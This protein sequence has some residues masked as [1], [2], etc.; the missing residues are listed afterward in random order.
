MEQLLELARER[1]LDRVGATY[2]VAAWILVQAASIALPAFAAPAWVLR[3]LIVAAMAGFPLVLAGA[4]VKS[5]RAPMAAAP[6]PFDRKDWLLTGLIGLVAVLLLVQLALGFSWRSTRSASQPMP[7][8][9]VSS[10]AVLPFANLS[11]DPSKAYFSDG[12]ADQLISELARTPS[13]RVAART[14]SF[15]FRGKDVDIKAIAKALNVRSVL[16]GSVREDGNRVRIAAELVDASNGFQIWSQ[17][18][19]RDL[20]SILALQDEI[21][22]SISRAL[23]QRFWGKPGTPARPVQRQR[24][25]PEV[26]KLYLQGQY[27]L[28]QRTRDGVTRAIDLFKRVTENAP[29]YADGI[30][31]LAD[32]KSVDALNFEKLDQVNAAATAADKALTLDPRNATALL[33]RARI[34]LLKWKWRAVA[35]DLRQLDRLHVNTAIVWR[36]KAVFF[37]YMGLSQFSGAAEQKA[38]Q[39]DPLSFLDHYNI[40]LYAM[41]SKHYD[42]AMKAAGDALALQP[43]NSE[44][45]TLQCEIENMQG[46]VAEARKIYNKLAALAKPGEPP[47]DEAGCLFYIVVTEKNYAAAHKIVDMAAA[48][49]PASGISATDIGIGYARAN[50]IDAAIKWFRRALEVRD[51]QVFRVP[52]FDRDMT[53]LFADPRWKMLRDTP[54]VRNWEEARREIAREFQMGE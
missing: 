45:L 22:G 29:D 1:K 52:Y 18:Y 17:T 46:R 19:D 27:Y 12:I 23:N 38:V 2:A 54:A 43:G 40:A 34:S 4:W 14:S 26:Y 36:T 49:F 35:D 37:D 25:D 13:L 51:P 11:G 33:A 41:L 7:Q 6:R 20:T 30:A 53:K 16:E 9:A 47:G 15:A 28:A 39:L 48:A 44:V 8:Q 31:S 10:V 24:I 5:S 32:A 21:A 50:D 42:D 3:W